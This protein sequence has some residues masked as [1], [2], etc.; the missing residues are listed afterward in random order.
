MF[1]SKKCASRKSQIKMMINGKTLNIQHSNSMF[2]ADSRITNC[3]RQNLSQVHML[4]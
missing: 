2:K 3:Y 1:W 4:E